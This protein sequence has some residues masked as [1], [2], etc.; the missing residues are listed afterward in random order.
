MIIVDSNVIIDYIN[1]DDTEKTI[2]LKKLLYENSEIGINT[3]IFFEVHLGNK[4]EKEKI[5]IKETLKKFVYFNISEENIINAIE[6]YNKCQKKGKTIKP[7]DTIIATHCIENGF[8]IL[9]NDNH[10]NIISI[11]TEGNL[12]I[13]Q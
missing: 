7:I 6:I 10:F 3:L 5:K 11:V 9:S 12:K 8:F 2:I 13:C 4:P 1:G